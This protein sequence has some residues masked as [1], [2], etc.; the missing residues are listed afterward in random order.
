MI[1]T[2]AGVPLVDLSTMATLFSSR[3]WPSASTCNR[4]RRCA[5]DCT[6]VATFGIRGDD[7]VRG[8]DTN[9]RFINSR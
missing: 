7:L 5:A 8:I 6:G 4:M 1:K 3:T 9:R 2:I